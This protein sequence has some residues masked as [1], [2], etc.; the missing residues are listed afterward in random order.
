MIKMHVSVPTD[1]R[2]FFGRQCPSCSQIF[3]VD[4]DAYDALP[5]DLQLWCVYCGHHADHSDFVTEQQ[6]AR[7]HRAARDWA[8][9]RV[10][11]MLDGALGGLGR[12]HRSSARSGL[13]IEVSYRSTPFVPRPLPG[14]NEEDLIRI[15]VCGECG[16]KYAVFSEHRFCPVCGLQP[17]VVVAQDSLSAELIKLDA[18]A[19]LPAVAAGPLREQGVFTKIWVDTLE[20]LVGLV[21]TLA[22]AVFRAAVSDAEIRV[23][24]A[25]G[26]VFQ[27]LDDVADLFVAAGYADLRTVLGVGVWQRLIEVWAIRHL[28]THTDGL[29]DQRFLNKV[30]SSTYTIGQRAVVTESLCRQ[31]IADVGGLC[32][33]ICGLTAP[34]A[35]SGQP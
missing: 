3:R 5:E 2:G 9:Q 33:A 10:H 11:Q 25:R 7:V 1:E 16:F 12:R 13:R 29:V 34:A 19:G 22:G 24:R 30:T 6:L 8:E 26:N 35:G 17:P 15:R 23:R 21:E 20:N 31:A 4:A 28:Y 14:I 32:S 27:R 18:L